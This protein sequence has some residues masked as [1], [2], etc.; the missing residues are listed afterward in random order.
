MSL[1]LSV[2]SAEQILRSLLWTQRSARTM[3]ASD[4][5]IPT[6]RA[7][8]LLGIHVIFNQCLLDLKKC[9]GIE[10]EQQYKI[11]PYLFKIK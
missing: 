10:R 1:F 7:Y 9:L 11:L 8:Q 3:E 5:G 6:Q 4:I 2:T